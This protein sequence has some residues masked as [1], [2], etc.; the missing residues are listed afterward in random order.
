MHNKTYVRGKKT[1]AVLSALLLAIYCFL[2][3]CLFFSQT[4]DTVKAIPAYSGAP[5]VEINGNRPGFTRADLT[6]KAYESYSDLDILGRCGMARANLGRETMP[7]GERSPIG[8]IKPSGWHTVKYDGIDG[9][10]LYN[11]CH[12]I[13]Y[14]LSGENANEKN[15]ITGTRYLNTQGML[16]FENMVADYITETGNHVLYRVT[17]VFHGVNLLA[18]GV[19]IEALSVEDRGEGICFNVFLYNVQPGIVIDYRDG[20]SRPAEN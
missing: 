15:L 7:R 19:Q 4:P 11:R 14:C 16:A 18:T 9:K 2:V 6:T 1:L 13:A 20:E 10:Y 8:Q 12:L 17:P 5:Y 3:I